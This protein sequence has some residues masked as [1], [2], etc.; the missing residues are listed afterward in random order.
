MT[1]PC[2]AKYVGQWQQGNRH[3]SGVWSARQREGGDGGDGGDG[4]PAAGEGGL[5]AVTSTYKGQW[6]DNAP[7][8]EGECTLVDGSRIRGTWQGGRVEMTVN[9]DSAGDSALVGSNTRLSLELADEGQQVV[10]CFYAN[11]TEFEGNVICVA[12]SSSSSSSS[13]ASASSSSS[14]SAKVWQRHGYGVFKE[15]DASYQVGSYVLEYEIFESIFSQ[16]SV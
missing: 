15:R 9:G 14:S 6:Q 12:S 4:H 7:C 1:W 10:Q 3:G 5:T 8:G 16:C 11:E 2:G 13:A